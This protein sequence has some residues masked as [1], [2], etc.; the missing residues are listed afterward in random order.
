MDVIRRVWQGMD[1]EY[2]RKLPDYIMPTRLQAVI[3]AR[4][5]MTGY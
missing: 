1:L 4:G 3:R 5:E 2:Y